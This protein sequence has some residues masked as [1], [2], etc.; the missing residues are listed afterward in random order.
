MAGSQDLPVCN[1]VGKVG[2][3]E[4]D[5]LLLVGFHVG[6]TVVLDD[7]SDRLDS[8]TEHFQLFEVACLPSFELS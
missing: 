8:A 7:S 1:I 4:S 6:A 2:S 3:V 5:V